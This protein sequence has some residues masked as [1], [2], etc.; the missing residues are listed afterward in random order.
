[1]WWQTSDDEV[2]P[3]SPLA[4]DRDRANILVY[5][6]RGASLDLVCYCRT[7]MAPL[8]VSFSHL[9]PS[10]LLT[11]EQGFGRKGGVTVLSCVYEVRVRKS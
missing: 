9:Q 7:E 5:G 1:M 6:L 2:Y 11:V 3:W 10:V 4:K 8:S